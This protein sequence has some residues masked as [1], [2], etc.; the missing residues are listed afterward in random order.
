M[1]GD[2]NPDQRIYFRDR[3]RA[4]RYAALADAEG[5]G[6]ICFAV[7][8]LGVHLADREDT[9]GKYLNR[10]R[11]IAVRSVVLTDMP[12][13]FPGLFSSFE[14]LYRSMQ[15]ARND[16]MHSGVYARHLTASAIELC[17]GLEEA[18]M[19]D[20]GPARTRVCDFMIRDAVSVKPWQPVAHARQMMLMHSFTYL[21]IQLDGQW[22]LLSEIAMAKFLPRGGDGRKV[23]FALSI[24]DASKLPENRLE[25]I[26]APVVGLEDD[27]AGHLARAS[28]AAPTLW[29]VV[30]ARGDLAGVLSPFELM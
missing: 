12:R 29:L 17:I 9:L 26:P 15:A 27:V 4:A 16:A 13:S 21:P 14:V 5:F 10:I 25:L 11:Q 19:Q 2:L 1:T 22:K 30:D 18:L 23:A 24:D 8:A 6:E 7:E 3:L 20:N 28:S